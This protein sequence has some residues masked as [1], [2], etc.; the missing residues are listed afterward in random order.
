MEHCAYRIL[1]RSL[2]AWHR[3]TRQAN[4]ERRQKESKQSYRAKMAAFL[5][6][7]SAKAEEQR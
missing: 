6:V 7:A 2:W 5:Q 4:A 1:K 3:V